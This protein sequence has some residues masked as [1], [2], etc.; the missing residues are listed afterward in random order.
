MGGRLMRKPNAEHVRIAWWHLREFRGLI[1]R[2]LGL[3]FLAS[4]FEMLGV[5]LIIP[6][7]DEMGAQGPPNRF[8]QYTDAL[9]HAAGLQR[10]FLGLLVLFCLFTLVKFAFT[11][12]ATYQSRVLSASL[13]YRMRQ[14][15]LENLMRLPLSFYYRQRMGDL[16]ST[17]DASATE[18]AA[19]AENGIRLVNMMIFAGAYVAIQMLI[20]PWMTLLVLVF[21]AISYY[22]ILPRFARSYT[23]GQE[24][25]AIIDET[26]S[27]LQDRLGGIKTI[28]AF[29]NEHLHLAEWD[30]LGKRLRHIAMY[31]QRNKIVAHLFGEPFTTVAV[32]LMLILAVQ[33][34]QLSVIELLAF[35]YAYSMLVPRVK[36]T[37]SEY[38]TISEKLAHFAKVHDLV[39]VGA[40]QYLPDGDV[41]IRSLGNGIRFEDVWFKYPSSQD[42]VLKGTS[43][44]IR[45]FQTT[46]L[47]GPSGVGKT[48]LADLAIRLH[49]PLKGR[50]LVDGR[51]LSDYS[52]DEWHRLVSAVEQDPYLF[53]DTIGNNIRY[54]KPGAT[55][56]EVREAAR[57]A[58]ADR[59]IDAL[60]DGYDTQVGQRG[61]ALSGGQRQR[62]ALARAMLR[63][64]ALLIL[65]E[66]TS[67][68]DS[69]SERFIRDA[70]EE[71]KTRCTLLIIAHRFTTILNADRIVIVEDGRVA[72]EGTH[73]ELLERQGLYHRYYTLQ[74]AS[75]EG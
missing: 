24:A 46:A 23:Q 58:H 16:I 8:T 56:A 22:F 40:D 54:G 18:S 55:D 48:T 30:A 33:V 41:P 73:R 65:D 4:L 42:W 12:S 64:P 35:F 26:T 51:P 13:R 31:I 49:D 1:A 2:C 25:K 27:F 44:E 61:M 34:L 63:Q 57:L 62:L 68:L 69:E 75:A 39:T 19:L 9:F 20:S 52:V 71:L 59:F 3:V 21:T 32:I 45:P 53:Y 50:I 43:F 72:E 28:K 10:S 5:A 36:A 7:L 29:G 74:T 47:V 6:L 70:I 15:I 11:E 38:L 67:A 17:T 14:R 66:A 37:N 60:P